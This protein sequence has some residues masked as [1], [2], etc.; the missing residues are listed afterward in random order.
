MESSSKTKTYVLLTAHFDSQHWVTIIDPLVF[1]WNP[2]FLIHALSFPKMQ[3]F[4]GRI[5]RSPQH[6]LIFDFTLSTHRLVANVFKTFPNVHHHLISFPATW[7]SHYSKSFPTTYRLLF[8]RTFLVK[9]NLWFNS[10]QKKSLQKVTKQLCRVQGSTYVSESTWKMVL[11]SQ[12]TRTT[13]NTQHML[14]SP[15]DQKM[16]HRGAV[17]H[18]QQEKD[19]K[20]CSERERRSCME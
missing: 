10:H 16:P 3:S 9:L 20:N 1:T 13:W 15:L 11:S 17:A 8:C 4:T 19:K 18:W 5:F 2:L 6:W 7:A 12:L 14:H